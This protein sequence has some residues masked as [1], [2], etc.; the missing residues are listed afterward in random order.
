MRYITYL[1]FALLAVSCFAVLPVSADYDFDDISKKYYDAHVGKG[2]YG[3]LWEPIPIQSYW[4][5][6]DFYEPPQSLQLEVT[7]QQCVACHLTVTAGHVYS[8]QKSG[9]ANL[10]EIRNLDAS[11]SRAYKKDLIK[12]VEQNLRKLGLLE[13]DK[14]LE[15]VGCI[16]CHGGVGKESIKHH[17]D[18]VMPDRVS[19]GVCH[20]SEFA[21]SESEREQEWP[22]NQWPKGH[23]SHAVDWNAN[24][25]TAIWAGMPQ[26]EIAQGCDMCHYN[27][28]KCDGCHTRHSFSAAEARM[29]EA[30]ATC[31]NGVDHNEFENY[32]LSKHGVIY[33][34]HGKDQWDWEV[35]LADAMTKGN[36]TA[37]TC[38]LC[39]FEFNGEFSHNTVRKVRW[40]F[41]PTPG[42]AD[43]L[44]HPWF[45]ERKDSWVAT[46]SM[47]HSPRFSRIWMDTADKGTIQGL[48]VQ[49][50][51][52]KILDKLYEDGLL[53]TKNRPAPPKPVE[54]AP[55]DF[56]AL[57]WAEENNPS[58][59]DRLYAEMW[60]HDAIKHMKGIFHA[61]PGGFTYTEGWSELIYRYTQ[62]HNEASRIREIA[63]LRKQVD[64]LMNR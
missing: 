40:G 12:E 45:E 59:M 56:F 37:P 46:C 54:D 15:E 44:S 28:N 24:V 51:A 35:P 55:G 52:K 36:Y 21:E 20:L 8:W 22:Q 60:E 13:K 41:N 7:R 58:L 1:K 9:H 29:P 30:C 27:Q 4:N 11:D 18:L 50:K 33:E 63:D 17:K 43:N 14:Q 25:H 6:K 39:H 48:E 19:C 64:Q 53:S 2:K 31:H 5:P 47:C 23:P 49:L 32:M 38:A 34:M 3:D 62:M 10:D 26:R 42:V 16:D 57:F 61:N